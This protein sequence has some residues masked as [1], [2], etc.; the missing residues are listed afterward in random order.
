MRRPTFQING[1]QYTPPATP[2]TSTSNY[3]NSS[4]TQRSALRPWRNLHL[5][6]SLPARPSSTGALAALFTASQTPKRSVFHRL[7]LPDA[8]RS[9]VHPSLPSTPE[10]NRTARQKQHV[11]STHQSEKS[12]TPKPSRHRLN[13]FTRTSTGF[14]TP[15]DNNSSP[16][17]SISTSS[18]ATSTLAENKEYPTIQVT[19]EKPASSNKFRSRFAISLSR[20]SQR[21]GAS[22]APGHSDDTHRLER[23]GLESPSK[24]SFVSQD[25][26]TS[27]STLC[28]ST[29]TFST[30]SH[31]SQSDNASYMA[32]P[33]NI[34]VK[35]S[36]A[37]LKKRTGHIFKEM[38]NNASS[39]ALSI[40]RGNVFSSSAKRKK[41]VVSG[42]ARGN[43]AAV[44]GL[45]KWC[46][47]RG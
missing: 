10:S 28:G 44:E 13:S 24:A 30:G 11:Y 12:V 45:R 39:S 1:H 22:Y 47:V 29:P 2:D 9:G 26:T 40:G 5:P 14:P 27:R 31:P 25:A 32:P 6:M 3:R 18:A 23:V 42:V 41:L 21:L 15:D 37:T 20:A 34:N 7:P 17:P 19:P 33:S 4:S 35:E 46:E 43:T 8:F 38:G 16:R 36:V